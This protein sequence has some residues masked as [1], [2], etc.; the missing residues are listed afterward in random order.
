MN[1]LSDDKSQE[2]KKGKRPNEHTHEKSSN[3]KGKGFS[4]G[5][6]IEC[7][8]CGGLWHYANDCPSLKDIKKS[9]QATLSNIDYEESASTA[10]EDAR[11]NPN[12]F[13]AFIAS[14][15]SVYDSDCDNDSDYEFIDEQRV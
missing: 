6:K 7:F 14:V 9:M 5:K 11:Y 1:L 2:S 12:D 13:L 3:D 4:K 8:K 10:S 15:E